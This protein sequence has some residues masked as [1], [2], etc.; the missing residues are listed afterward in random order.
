MS[1]LTTVKKAIGVKHH[2]IWLTLNKEGKDIEHRLFLADLFLDV[3]GSAEGKQIWMN[4][5]HAG[6]HLHPKIR[7]QYLKQRT[8]IFCGDAIITYK[9]DETNLEER[10][11]RCGYIYKEL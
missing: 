4:L 5:A 1:N 6:V 3:E 11:C 2:P 9:V 8:C 7:E 10:C